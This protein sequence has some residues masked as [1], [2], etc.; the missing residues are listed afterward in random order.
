MSPQDITLLWSALFASAL[1]LGTGL[2][3]WLATRQIRHVQAHRA[4]VPE[5]FAA[6]IELPTHQKAADYTVA[7]A[8]F[9]MWHT[10]FSAALLLGWT[11]FGG[12]QLLS[13]FTTA[14]FGTHL[15]AQLLLLIEFALIAAII[16]LPWDLWQT[17]RL[18]ARFGF[19][20]NTPAL[21]LGDMLKNL[22]V[23]AVLMLP[24]AA[25]VLWLMQASPLWW[26]WAW[27]AFAAFSLVMMVVFPMFIA[28]LFNRFEPLAEG[29]VKGR[30]QALMQR[31]DFALQGLYVMDGSRRSAH[32]NAYFTGLGAARR[33]VLFDTLLKQLDAAQI[34]AVLAH[35][36]GHY[37]RRHI[38]QRLF[39]TLLLSLTGFALLGWLTGGVWFYTGLGYTPH[40]LGGN[41]A[42]ALI[43]FMLVL[44]V[45]GVFFTP[46]GASWSRKHEFEADAY[47]AEHSDARQLG[48]ALIRMYQ[49]NA[50]TLTPDP[51]YVRFY[52]SHPPALQ[53]LARM[54]ALAALSA[55]RPAT[56]RLRSND[57]PTQAGHAA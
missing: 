7:R 18:E 3:L 30:A 17:F 13:D 32:A 55:S 37:K 28:P 38:Q 23:S 2:K 6:V 1:V 41:A 10:L 46:L 57:G 11:L 20:R 33:V 49:D 19:N 44:P 5:A 14:H 21:F 54:G 25:L 43:L 31:C 12:L 4:Q 45:F 40:L 29:E 36:V 15:G 42:A 16:D 50:T 34:E 47:A 56:T 22:L 53:R 24:L 52:Y 9:G 51:L 27:A 8:R 35:E 26:L 39:T 48:A